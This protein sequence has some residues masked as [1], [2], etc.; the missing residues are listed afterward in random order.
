MFNYYLIIRIITL[1]ACRVVVQI[2]IVQSIHTIY[3]QLKIIE[4]TA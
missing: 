4:E 2:G 3:R 1:P